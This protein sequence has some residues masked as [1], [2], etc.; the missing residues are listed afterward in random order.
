MAMFIQKVPQPKVA[1]LQ[2]ETSTVDKADEVC[3]RSTECSGCN[4]F[5]C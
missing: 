1:L 3:L 4:V 5:W 2:K